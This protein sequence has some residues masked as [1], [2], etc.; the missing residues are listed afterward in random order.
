MEE[1]F[2]TVVLEMTLEGRLDSKKIKPVNPK[3]NHPWI[4]TVKTDAETE[5]QRLWPSDVKNQFIGIV[6]DAGKDWRQEENRAAKDEIVGWHH[7]LNGHE[8]EKNLGERKDRE[9]GIQQS[10]GMKR[11]RHESATE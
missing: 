11:V 8:F 1:C 3:G 5:A 4:F 7:Q 10:M 9:C 6:P 2:Q